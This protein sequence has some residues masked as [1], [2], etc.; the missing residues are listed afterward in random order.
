VRFLVDANLPPAL[1]GWL[2]RRGCEAAHVFD[3]GLTSSADGLIRK[4]AMRTGAAIIT[5]DMDFV[6]QKAMSGLPVPVVIHVRIGNISTADLQAVWHH[7]W[8]NIKADL[9]NGQHLLFV[10]RSPE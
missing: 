4:E 7:Q 9:L 8:P 6:I 2:Q 10:D 3:I 5:K 1:V